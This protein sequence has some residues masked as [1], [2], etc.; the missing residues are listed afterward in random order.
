MKKVQSTIDDSIVKFKRNAI[1]ILGR[2][3]AQNYW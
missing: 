3:W 2:E 1:E